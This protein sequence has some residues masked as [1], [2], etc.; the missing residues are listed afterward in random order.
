[1]TVGET[2]YILVNGAKG[3]VSY[4]SSDKNTASVNANGKIKAKRPGTVKITV[5]SSARASYKKA[6][7]T[8]KIKIV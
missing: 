7:K 5:T 2:S 3:D 4:K 8:I 6:K 1:M